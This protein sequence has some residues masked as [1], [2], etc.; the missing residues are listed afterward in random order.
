[1]V[2]LIRRLTAAGA[3]LF[4]TFT[5][6]FLVLFWLPGDPALLV[7]GDE[8]SPV[9]V[10]NLRVRLGTDVPIW[11]QYAKSLDRLAH[12]DFGTSFST[13]EPVS[14]RLAAQ[15]PA[16]VELTVCA[17]AIAILAGVA[18]GVTAAV[19]RGGWLDHTI[20][21]GML[22][23]T[24]MP[25]FWLGILLILLFSVRLR[26]LPA[27]GSGTLRQ[28]ILPSLCLGLATSARL[29]RMVRNSVID[30]LDAPFVT[31]LRGKGLREH[32][33]LYRHVLRNALIP[34]ITVFGLLVG[35]LISGAVVVETLF[36]RQGVGRLLV[37]AVGVK[38]IPVVMGVT[39]L[40]SCLYVTINLLVDISYL[41]I[42]RRLTA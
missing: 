22:F 30:V 10:A 11:Q 21:T 2:F 12:G 29:A 8:A 9:T 20:Q 38:D 7:A 32:Q 19:Q 33:V 37:E 26:W 14:Q 18:L 17:C 42:D 1:M 3:V 13:N 35:E 16:T 6:V 39:M 36:A 4:G 5:L 41:W 15:F 23:F 24:S 28:L 34:V 40:A 25:A 27:L 31:T